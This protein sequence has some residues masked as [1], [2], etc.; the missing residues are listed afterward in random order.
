MHI[1]HHLQLSTLQKLADSNSVIKYSD[2][3]DGTIE[4]SLF[5]YHL[6]KL[7]QRGMVEKQGDGYTL[8]IE[9][10]RWLNDNGIG[11]R[12]KESPRIS[13]AVVV[14]NDAGEFLI[15]QRTGQFK[16]MINDYFLPSLPYTNDADIAE[17]ISG[18]MATYIPADCL[19]EQADYGFAQIRA[20]Y[21]DNAVMRRLFS[22]TQCWTTRFEPLQNQPDKQFEWLSWEQ[23]QA[24]EHPS[25]TI[26]RDIIV[27]ANHSENTH[28]T[29]LF[30]G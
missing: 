7:I 27:F 13:V 15:G 21:I 6:N 16:A 30:I 24:I 29:P 4:N 14:Q 25:A 17:Q 28:T 5:S 23:I 9:G 26:L 19:I 3:K 2:L 12:P 20:T 18:V 22:I 11:L 8:T 1:D 10:S